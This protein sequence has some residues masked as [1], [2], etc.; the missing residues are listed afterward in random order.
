MKKFI[1]LL[2]A[3][4]V[5]V[6]SF[7]SCTRNVEYRFMQDATQICAIEIVQTG[8][9]D[10]KTGVLPFET[11]CAI[12]EVESFLEEFKNLEC[13]APFRGPTSAPDETK[14]FRFIYQDGG[15]ELVHY[16]GQ[17]YYY[18]NGEYWLWQGKFSFDRQEFR[19]LI[20]KY[21]SKENTGSTVV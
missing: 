16:G 5:L 4:L 18:G 6:C 8:I 1:F 17:S 11:I 9:S 3:L 21:Q 15:Y 7:T 12:E 19:D 14:M 2:C 10:K 20:K 13:R